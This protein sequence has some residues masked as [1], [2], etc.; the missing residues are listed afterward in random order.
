MPLGGSSV[1]AGGNY[2]RAE[3]LASSLPALL[4][5]AERIAATVAQGIHGRRRVGPGETF[6]QFRRYE[7]G[8]SASRIDWRKS[9]RSHRTYIRQTEWE[10]AQSV[11]LWR[12]RSPSME[13]RSRPDWP[14]KRERAELMLLAVAAL[15]AR[16]GERM[17][18]LGHDLAPATGRA[19][20]RRLATTLVRGTISGQ[21]DALAEDQG[22]PTA[23]PLPRHSNLV[24]F[25]DFLSPLEDIQGVVTHYAGRGIRGHL[26]QILD[27]AE[28]TLPFAGRVRFEGVENDGEVLIRRVE[29]VRETYRG[30]MAAHRAELNTLAR[31]AGWTLAVDHTDRPP[32]SALLALYLALS[33]H[34]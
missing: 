24:L 4:V 31:A 28:E 3:A 32:Q 30:A 26:V 5:A 1:D 11:W 12:D 7:P 13:W 18:L 21:P 2:L 19:T 8:D 33:E 9:A 23:Q 10:A 15:L 17:A 25:G 14:T 6:W 34:P 20:V 22:L 27:P 29:D 16:G